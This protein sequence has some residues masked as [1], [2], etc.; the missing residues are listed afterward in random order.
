MMK[1]EIPQLEVVYLKS[2]KNVVR[3][4]LSP[5]EEVEGNFEK[6]EEGSIK[7]FLF[8]KSKKGGEKSDPILVVKNTNNILEYY[9]KVIVVKKLSENPPKTLVYM[10]SILIGQ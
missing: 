8:F 3:Q 9:T 4:L 7:G 1:L 2:G 10:P 6:L 5:A